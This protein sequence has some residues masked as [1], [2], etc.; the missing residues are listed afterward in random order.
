MK[1]DITKLK[2]K[3]PEGIYKQL[4]LVVEKFKI[5][6]VLRMSH[7][8]AQCGHESGGFKVFVENLNYPAQG[9]ANTFPNRYAVNPKVTPKVPNALANSLA[10]KPEAIANNLYSN[11][12]GNGSEVSGE[13][14][15]YR[16]RGAIQLTGKSNYTSFGNAIKENIVENPDV[17]ATTHSMVSA[18]WFFSSNGLNE[19]S[20]RGNT[21]E[22]VTLVTKRVNGGT[23]GLE[24]RIEHFNEFYSILNT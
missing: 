22:I 16:G 11:R 5:D 6:T 8:L 19:I 15:K 3:L 1:L 20:D 24:Q 18:A 17:V 21:K 10:R 23:H 4:P 14:W 12:M 13:G 2:K 9:L 7:F